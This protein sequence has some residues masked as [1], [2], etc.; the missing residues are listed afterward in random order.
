MPLK[1][2]MVVVAGLIAVMIII[3][4]VSTNIGG[5]ENMANN[6]TQGGFV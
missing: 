6:T 2:I 5:V 4:I 3:S 1:I